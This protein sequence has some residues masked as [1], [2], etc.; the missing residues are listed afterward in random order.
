M[1]KS[2][3]FQTK[4]VIVVPYQDI[5]KEQFHFLAS[6]LSSV[7]KPYAQAIEHV[8]S[9]SIIGCFAKPIIDVDIIVRQI[10]FDN[11]KKVLEDHGFV[12]R[13]DLGIPQRY[14]FSGPDVGFKYHLY[15]CIDE[16]PNLKEHL[17]LRNYLL[18]HELDRDAYGTLKQELATTYRFDID[19][20]IDGKSALIQHILQ[21]ARKHSPIYLR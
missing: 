13:G 14:A 18:T 1:V 17:L 19:S 20:Y 5:W 3:A 15:V 11:I 9:T 2:V 6:M 7:V 12:Y 4:E 10:Q 8:G 16:A 21:D